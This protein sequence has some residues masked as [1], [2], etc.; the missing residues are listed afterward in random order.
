MDLVTL[1][2]ETYYDQDY[3][4]SKIT[5]EE[6]VRSPLFEVIGVGVKIND[7]PARWFR[8]DDVLRTSALKAINWDNTAV[9]CHNTVFD[10]AILSWRFGIKPKMYFDTLS[11]ARPIHTV[12]VGGSLKALAEYYG[13]GAK[14]DEVFLAKGKHL[15][16]FTMEE[17]ARYGQYCTNDVELT[18][19]LFKKLK[20]QLPISE[21]LV[22]DQIL[23]MFIDPQLELD[24]DVLEAHLK[25]TIDRKQAL[26]D[27]F[28][29]PAIKEILM[30]NQ[31]F[32]QA[33]EALGVDVPMKI[34]PRTGNPTFAFGK[35]DKN[36]L[37]LQEHNDQRVV[38]LV[39]AR[40]GTKSTIEQTRT[41]RLLGVESRGSL[42]VML[43]YYAAH[44]GRFGGG[45]KMNL[46]N[47][48]RGGELRRAIKAPKGKKIVACD[49]SQIEA[50][51]LAWLAGQ[52]DLVEAFREGRDIYSEFATDV[53]GIPI[54]K[55][56]K[57][58]RF[59]GKT[60]ILGL[61]YGMGY[62]KL[63]RTL[64]IGQGGIS[65]LIEPNDAQRIVRLY[66][67]TYFKI[68]QLWKL[69]GSVLTDLVNGKDGIIKDLLPYDNDSIYLPNGLRIH[70]PALQIN[71]TSGFRYINDARQFREML[72][73]RVLGENMD[74]LKWTYLYGGKVVEN[75]VQ[76]LARIVVSEQMAA[77]GQRYKTALQVHDE[78]VCVVAEEEAEECQA[79]ME[80]VMRTPPT[81]A[82]NLPVN[83]ESGV[84]D[85]YATAK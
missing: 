28:E 21:L 83:C 46:Q 30:S 27:Q 76:A 14:G 36:F 12:T 9:L 44:T 65:V 84:G 79:F 66:R 80:R 13:L 59:V 39:E 50:R 71:G 3:S 69:C 42:P 35:S 81:W 60:C 1:D 33:L 47:L 48:P 77:I 62:E 24:K 63:Q 19:K 54:N 51:M 38:D 6:Y 31:K 26:L 56:M 45:D 34:S 5:T 40:L 41:Q 53:Y 11:M 17:L 67:N 72:K 37:A 61:G 73:R 20:P 64:E 55:S 23:R 18:Y 70:Y 74:D 22:I 25:A 85:N 75:I 49:S 58:E 82:A 52:A 4:L 15:A 16:D 32:A 68:P 8:G 7:A 2:W 57:V 29:N 43:T 78:I 10:G